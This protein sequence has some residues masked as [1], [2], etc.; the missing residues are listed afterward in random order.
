MQYLLSAKEMKQAD[1]NTITVFGMSSMVLMER[2]ALKVIEVIK[3]E[4]LDASRTL[5][6]CGTGNNGGDGMAAAR[7][8]HLAGNEVRVCLIGS[9]E[10]CSKETR[11]QYEI[12]QAYGIGVTK[13]LSGE[14]GRGVTLV[15]DALFG[16][17]LSRDLE[18]MYADAVKKMNGITAGKLAVDIPSG[19]HADSGAVMGC[20]FHADH[21]VSFAYIKSGLCF[22][23]GAEEAGKV[24]VADIGISEE[25]LLKKEPQIRA[26]GKEDL[27]L[28]PKIKPDAHKGSCGKLLVIA[29]SERIAGAAYL[30]AKA[31]Y[32]TGCGY[33]KIFTHEKNRTMLNEKI[34]EA[35]LLTYTDGNDG[36]WKDELAGVL[37]WADAVVIGPGLGVTQGSKEILRHVLTHVKTPVVADAD[38]LNLMADNRDLLRSSL[39]NLIVTPHLMEMARLT[40]LPVEEI[41]RDLI[42]TAQR[43]A[44]EYGVLCVEKD[45]RT[46]T[47]SAKGRIYVN[48]S[49]NP[50]MATAGSGDVLSGMIAGL[51]AGG[52]EPELAAAMGVF[53][54]GCAGDVMAEKTGYRSLMA[55]DILEGIK[56]VMR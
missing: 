51:A 18:G 22:Y 52:M 46:V 12:L 21:T 23:P 50:G 48:L 42:G 17:G 54:H 43:F 2:A 7:M 19:I 29:G 20:C 14:E 16:I 56:E 31:A 30:T 6:V 5:V 47:A 25:S 28:L 11:Q 1:Q 45:A 39:G 15:I 53:L 13:G 44:E 3:R 24:H 8:L 9:Y 41:R 40:G 55:G 36:G 37:S 49:G 10:K 27:A 33:V 38:A 4:G 35:V 26:L 34:P 32:L